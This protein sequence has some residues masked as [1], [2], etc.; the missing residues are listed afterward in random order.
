MGSALQPG[1]RQLF[2]REDAGGEARWLQP[3]EINP[4]AWGRIIESVRP[5]GLGLDIPATEKAVKRLGQACGHQL[6]WITVRRLV[7]GSWPA[8]KD[9]VMALER[10]SFGE[11]NVFD[12]ARMERIF[13]DPAGVNLMLDRGGE[14]A[15]FLYG[16]PL[17]R[18]HFADLEQVKSDPHYGE[19]NTF[20]GGAIAVHPDFRG[21]GLSRLL[22]DG[23][24]GVLRDMQSPEGIQY[25]FFSARTEADS[26]M[27]RMFRRMGANIKVIA[28]GYAKTGEDMA[29]ITLAIY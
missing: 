7:L 27:T 28:G 12:E 4:E 25:K 21:R 29:Y 18:P 20:Y 6:D 13:T 17:E 16:G 14:L 5:S 8:V 15:G 10:L 1:A 26:P 19:H 2:V 24:W 22:L 23:L 3:K 11:K 9:R